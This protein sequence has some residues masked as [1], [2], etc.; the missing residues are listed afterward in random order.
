MIRKVILPLIALFGFVFALQFTIFSDRQTLPAPPVAV[1]AASGY[2]D[3][4]S[5]SGI[6]EANSEN[7]EVGTPIGGVVAEIYVEVG[8]RV[9]AGDPL[10]KLDD[11]EIKA[12]VASRES[13]LQ[14]SQSAIAEAEAQLGD[15]SNQFDIAN[16]LVA[17]DAGSAFNR[18][19]RRYATKV[20]EA[21]L[22]NARSQA[23]LARAQLKQAQTNLERHIVRAPITGEVLKVNLR[24]GEFAQMGVLQDPLVLM[25]NITPLHVRV[26]ID[27]NDAW[28]FSPGAKAEGA[29]RGNRKIKSDLTFVRTEPYVRPKRSLTGDS[30]ERV[31]TRVLQVIFRIND[32]KLP[33]YVGQLMDVFVEAKAEDSS[34]PEATPPAAEAQPPAPPVP[35]AP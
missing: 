12:E 7:I 32:D 18:D 25:G 10:F 2:R 34:E 15:A 24:L 14:A 16:K 3:F 4:I 31:D 17:G 13:A 1:P 20:A 6:I 30:N 28:R 27:E 8:S 23:E 33:V 22:T 29:L 35:P 11:R 9:N 21:R 26:D 5:G 19:R